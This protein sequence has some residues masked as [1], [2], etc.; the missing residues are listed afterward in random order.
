MHFTIVSYTFPPSKQIGGR[1]WAKFSQ[2]L[3]CQGH[4]VTVVCANDFYDS[5]YYKKEFSGIEV[6][7]LPKHYPDWL[8]GETKSFF[9]K[10]LYFFY[11]RVWSLFTKQNLFDKGYA[12]KKPML[13][14]LEKLHQ[15][16]KIG[17][18]IVTGAPFSLLYYGAEFKNRHKEIKYI[19]DWRDPWTWGSYYGIPDLSKRKKKYQEYSEQTS[20]EACDI[21]TCP[22]QNMIEV[23]RDK[24]PKQ[25]SK[26]Y[27]LPHAYEPEKF[28]ELVSEGKREGFIYGGTLYNGIEV[29]I[30]SLGEIVKANPDSGFKWSSYT[31]TSYPLLDSLFV[32]EQVKVSPLVPE[33]I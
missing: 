16:R 1:R 23:L 14:T 26:C 30:K 7:V 19:G 5:A 17:V 24:Y 31:A 33:E 3:H 21:I 10:I 29:Y 27:L 15:N 18:L 6:V 8:T 4:H 32:N 20:V 2:H 9:E 25:A 22:T 13:S 11:T 28:P 12:W